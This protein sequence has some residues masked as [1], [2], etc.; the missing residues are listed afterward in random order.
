[1]AGRLGGKVALVTGAASGIGRASAIVFAR[2]GAR[3]IVA[4]IDI[5]G[6]EKTVQ[7][8]EKAGGEATFVKADVTKEAE[9]EVMVNRTI[10]IYGQLNCAYNNAGI[11]GD[12]WDLVM[13][14][15]LKGVWLCMKY[16]V[17]QMLKQG[18]GAIVNT[19]SIVGLVGSRPTGSAVLAG[20][21]LQPPA[22][23]AS[24]HGVMGLTRAMALE[25]AKSNIRIN[26]ICP[27]VIRTPLMERPFATIP[28]LEEQM[29]SL[30]PMGR[31][32]EPEEV[33][34][35]VVWLCS[36]AASFVTGIAMPV[37]GGYTAQ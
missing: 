18:G 19:S 11:A 17:L 37:D 35:A 29:I 6:S 20:D 10:E 36:D 13:D 22:Y 15:N 31:L 16:E 23:P 27:G 9:V 34:E 30:H 1:M 33:A 26:A 5:G 3:V 4:D 24:K 25:C 21:K 2:E 14:I 32:G 8:I 28:H 7:M 12:D